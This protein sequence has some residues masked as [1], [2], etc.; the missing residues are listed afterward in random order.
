MNEAHAQLVQMT[1]MLKNLSRWLEAGVEHA[2]AKKFDPELLLA[3]RLAPDMYPLT[4]QIQSAS[5]G[6][7]F[8]AARATGT[9]APSHPDT[10]TT[11]DQLRARIASILSYVEG[12]KPEQFEGWEKRTITMSFLPGKGSKAEDWLH[13]MSLPNTY[14]HFAMAYAILRHS[15]VTLGKTDY[16]GS[17]NLH[18]V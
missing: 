15:G 8:L 18:D 3:Q 4:Q 1:K 7:K 16:I 5:D 12:F 6:V 2:K 10:E 11:V 9:Q 14:F 17:L 13:E